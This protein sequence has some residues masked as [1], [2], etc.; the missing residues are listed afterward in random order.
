M[1]TLGGHAA[2]ILDACLMRLEH[3][4][5]G[6]ALF[7]ALLPLMLLMLAPTQWNSNEEN[8]FQLAYQQFAPEKFGPHHAVFDSAK[9]RIVFETFLGAT[10]DALGY[11]RAHFVARIGLAFA[12]AGS[13]AVFFS[14]VEI[15]VLESLVVI[16]VFCA[17]G[18]QLF[19]GEW[20]FKGVEAKTFAYSLVF[21]A[22]GFAYRSRWPAAIALA[23]AATYFH[24]LV[25]GFWTLMLLFIQFREQKQLKPVL[26]SAAMFA[27]LLAPLLILV[28]PHDAA[29]LVA[30]SPSQGPSVDIIYSEIR[31]A[32]HVAPFRTRWDFWTWLPGI[33]VAVSLLGVLSGLHRRKY[34]PPI[35][36]AAITALSFL[37]FALILAFVDRHNQYLGKFYLFR[38][39]SLALFLTI[40]AIL[41][42]IRRQCPD[43]ARAVL[44]LVAAAFIAVFAWGTLKTQVDIVRSAPAIPHEQELIAA[45]DR[46]SGPK[47]IVLIEPFNEMHTDYVRLHRVIPRPTL[48]AWKFAPTDPADLLRWYDLIQRREHLFAEGC[49]APMQPPV[50]FLLIFRKDT[51]DRMREC[52]DVIWKR[53][54]VLLMRVRS[55]ATIAKP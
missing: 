40:S 27:V 3:A 28:V 4:R 25:G 9:A 38:P 30:A 20:L 41:V 17:M 26:F 10:V 1:R 15:G 8:Y 51:A 13:L 35:G 21:V 24:F 6:R 45:I 46:N 50:Q 39:S 42:A 2:D 11:E 54:E 33:V 14:A 16:A 5:S 31:G 37:L 19:G 43:E 32:E 52:G 47:D 12:Y 36:V 7:T 29:S 53:D 49:V 22:L 48:V 23:A 55:E 44:R 18:E 34:L